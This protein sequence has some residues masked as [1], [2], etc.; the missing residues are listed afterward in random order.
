MKELREHKAGR[1]RVYI[2]ISYACI[3]NLVGLGEDGPEAVDDVGAWR[4]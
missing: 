3:S 4:G 2:F 1:K